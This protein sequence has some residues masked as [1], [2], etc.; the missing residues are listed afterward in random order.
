[1]TFHLGYKNLSIFTSL[2]YIVN[3]SQ[4]FDPDGFKWLEYYYL[5]RDVD[6]PEFNMTYHNITHLDT[7]EPSGSIVTE[8]NVSGLSSF[9]AF[10]LTY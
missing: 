10:K 2:Q 7:V 3:A 4:S 9:N 5:C 6:G 1:M 8:A